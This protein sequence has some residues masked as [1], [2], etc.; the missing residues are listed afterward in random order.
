MYIYIY[1]STSETTNQL[2]SAETSQHLE[3]NKFHQS[4]QPRHNVFVLSCFQNT[5]LAHL[6]R[7]ECWKSGDANLDAELIMQ[8]IE[9]TNIYKHLQTSTNIYKQWN[10]IEIIELSEP[11][12]LLDATNAGQL[13]NSH[14]ARLHLQPHMIRHHSDLCVL[15]TKDCTSAVAWWPLGHIVRASCCGCTPSLASCLNRFE[16]V[17]TGLDIMIWVCLKIVYPIVPN[18]FADHYPVSKWLFHWEYTQHFQ[19]PTHMDIV[20]NHR[21]DCQNLSCTVETCRAWESH[22]PCHGLCEDWLDGHHWWFGPLFGFV[23]KC[24]KGKNKNPGVKHLKP[25]FP[26]RITMNRQ[27]YPK[28]IHNVPHQNCHHLVGKKTCPVF[29]MDPPSPRSP[30]MAGITITIKILWL[31]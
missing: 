14:I 18:G 5:P 24:W 3:V 28:Q 16:W 4:M 30:S 31:V 17:W 1:V 13:D 29:H 23:W 7:G 11:E 10:S 2:T 15:D 6:K 9:A 20:D 19:L 21:R 27:L 8:L 26:H 22:G 12:T 25:Q